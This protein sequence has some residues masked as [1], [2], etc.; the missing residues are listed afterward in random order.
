MPSPNPTFE[1]IYSKMFCKTCTHWKFDG[2]NK[3]KRC[4][5]APEIQKACIVSGINSDN[6]GFMYNRVEAE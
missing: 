3:N 6:P 5:L 2:T 4:V 1:K